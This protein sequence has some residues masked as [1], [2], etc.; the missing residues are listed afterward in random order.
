MATGKVIA[1][2]DDDET[3]LHAMG[4]LLSALGFQTELYGSAEAFIGSSDKVGSS[5]PPCRHPIG[6]SYWH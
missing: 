2:I 3:I 6:R 5:V 1:V 4:Y